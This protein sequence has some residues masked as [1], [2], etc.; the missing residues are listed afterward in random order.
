MIKAVAPAGQTVF[1]L[2]A[3][4]GQDSVLMAS[5]GGA[6]RV[7]MIERDPVV[8]TLL[9]DALRR[10]HLI[11]SN[12]EQQFDPCSYTRARDLSKRLTLEDARDAIAFTETIL[13]DPSV[14]KP[15]ICY[16]DPMF[17]PR[18]KSSL[19]KKNMQI[20]HSFLDSQSVETHE[21]TRLHEQALFESAWSL[22]TRR[23]VVKRPVQADWLG[24]G[25]SQNGLKPAHSIKGSVNRW[26]VYIK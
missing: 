23:V 8:S 19:V 6:F 24:G 13:S 2:T 14:Q 11:A 5:A 25:N 15:E 10:L 18:S 12:D 26:D 16:L 20:L 21:S 3:G 22:A 1:D 17:P 7:H 4:F 9:S